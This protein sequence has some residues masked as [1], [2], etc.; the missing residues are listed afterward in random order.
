MSK[1]YFAPQR[2]TS[3]LEHL[4]LLE[5]VQLDGQ[6]GKVPGD[7]AGPGGLDV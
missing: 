7:F 5:D 4:P 6:G 1:R 2:C 3:D